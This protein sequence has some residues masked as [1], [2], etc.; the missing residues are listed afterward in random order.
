MLTKLALSFMK[1]QII[2]Y[3]LRILTFY[4]SQVAFITRQVIAI[5]LHIRYKTVMDSLVSDVQ[6]SLDCGGKP[7]CPLSNGATSKST[8][9]ESQTL[10]QISN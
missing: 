8:K 9:T 2:I 3:F 10:F 4:F 6:M 7:S 1:A 5:F